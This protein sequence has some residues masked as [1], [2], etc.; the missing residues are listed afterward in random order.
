M[1]NVY[2]L[3]YHYDDYEN[4]Y[5]SVVC[6]FSN[7]EDA[8]RVSKVDMSTLRDIY[9]LGTA[10]WE[11]AN[12]TPARPSSKLSWDNYH[13]FSHEHNLKRADAYKQIKLDILK[14]HNLPLEL[15]DFI[16][17]WMDSDRNSFSVQEFEVY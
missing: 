1:T 5:D 3:M 7:K 16:E 6:L 4:C 13:K 12:P 9:L 10:S 17:F 11:S 8:N 2:A 15:E 14:E